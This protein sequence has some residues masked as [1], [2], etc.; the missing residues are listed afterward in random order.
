MSVRFSIIV[1]TTGRPTLVRALQSLADQPLADGDEVLVVGAGA[2]AA[3]RF[4]YRHVPCASGGDWGGTERRKG[5]ALAT[6]THLAFLDDD[7]VYLPGAFARM[8]AAVIAAPSRPVMFR[9]I[10]VDGSTLWRERRVAYGNHGT[11]QFVTPNVA[12][13]VGLWGTD[14]AGDTAF[15]VDTL[16]RYEPDALVWDE[17]VTYQCRPA[18]G[19]AGLKVLLV[20]PGTSVAPADVC[21]GLRFGLAHHGVD[22]VDYRLD[23][24]IDHSHRWLYTAWRRARRSRPDLQRPTTADVFYQAGVDALASALR[25]QV[26]AV[27]IV[28]AMYLHPDV[29]ILMKRAG[30]R[31]TVLF[32]ETPYDIEGELAIAR[33][34]DGC[35][36]HERSAVETFRAANPRSGYVPHGWHPERHRP[37]PQPGD[38]ALPQH[39]VVFVGSGNRER[40]EWL[41]AIDWTGIDL[42][43][44]GSWEFLA[45]RSPLRKFI[46]GAQTANAITAALYRRAKIGLNLYRISKGWGPKAPVIDRAESLNP[47]AYELAA[48]GA[49]HISTFRAEVPEVFGDL[50][51]TFASAFDASALIRAWLADDAGRARV[52]AALPARV[53]DASWV[54]R[55]RI[56]IGD[57]A[58][59]V[60]DGPDATPQRT[61]ASAV[62]AHR[63]IVETQ[64]GGA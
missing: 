9:M 49:F 39:D 45:S 20:N 17:T 10:N 22:I 42:G 61:R 58:T 27:V 36:T 56:V 1:A 46:R 60:S 21:A 51:P 55:T 54:D 18:V 50:V 15:V 19:A 4:G 62:G 47:R 41:S 33:M 34:V 23:S 43:L 37:G 8:R 32:T 30:L 5:I 59:L 3:R 25:H 7:D 48:C 16:R 13:K 40:V 26:D 64:Q 28:S 2:D 35:W 57:L 53:A 31:V 52:A 14:Y 24:R 11:P 44:Y 29:I 63:A 6:G 38:E 12:G